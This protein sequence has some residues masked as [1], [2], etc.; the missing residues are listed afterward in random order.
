MKKCFITL[1]FLF[2][3]CLGYAQPQTGT[4]EMNKVPHSSLIYELD[5]SDEI[6]VSALEEKMKDFGKLPKKSKGFYKYKNVVIPEISSKPLQ[7]YF[8][9]ERKSKKDKNKSIL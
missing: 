6:V 8:S 1:S 5:Y 3:V 4:T 9:V 2:S 7:V